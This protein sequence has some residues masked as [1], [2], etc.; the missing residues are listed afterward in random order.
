MTSTLATTLA[1]DIVFAQRDDLLDAEL[2]RTR[3]SR[4]LAEEITSCERMRA[5]Y[6][7]GRS[8]RLLWRVELDDGSRRLVSGRAFA[9]GGSRSRYER[10][11][12]VA[13]ELVRH[14][15]ELATVFLVFPADR[16]LA[17]LARLHD[18]NWPRIPGVAVSSYRLVAYAPERAATA[19]AADGDGRV[20]AFVKLHADATAERT[21]RVHSTLRAHGLWVPAVLAS[22][23]TLRAVAIEPA[24]GERLDDA[25]WPAFGA[26]LARLHR[27]APV[28][29]RRST[30]LVAASLDEAAATIAAVRPDAA[31]AAFDLVRTLCTRGRQDTP[32]VCLH[33]DAHPK[34]VVVDGERAYLVDLDDVA[35]GPAEAE[36]GSVLAGI[37]FDALLGRRDPACAD[38]FLDAYG[39]PDRDALRRHT[40]AAL[41]RERALRSVTRLRSEGLDRLHE[42]L[43]AA[44]EELG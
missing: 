42:V 13:G 8:L 2:L 18:G 1:P 33:G 29:E 3:L 14:D 4:V 41:L 5:T 22:W 12:A 21:A 16:K 17:A 43:A 11:R 32:D 35:G 37:R 7:P 39:K 24:V 9:R 28:D 31:S 26:A 6:H 38:A 27:L 19:A 36:V 30:R 40:A 20:V 44:R 34:N 15:E 10:A 23:P 25:G